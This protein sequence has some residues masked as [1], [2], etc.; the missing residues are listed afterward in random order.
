[1]RIK[2]DV[3]RD[4]ILQII[5]PVWPRLLDTTLLLDGCVWHDGT[6]DAERHRNAVVVIAVHAHA[7]GE[8]AEWATVYLEPIIQLFGLHAEFR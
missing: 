4:L 2:E 3:S 6:Q 7:T 5:P 1:M 8:G